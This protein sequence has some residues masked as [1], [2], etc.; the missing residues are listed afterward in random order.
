[1]QTITEG[2]FLYNRNRSIRI[3]QL[4][5]VIGGIPKTA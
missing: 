4:L 1:M 3:K 5:I 2:N